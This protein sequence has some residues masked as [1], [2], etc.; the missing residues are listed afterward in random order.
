MVRI[1]QK[2]HDFIYLKNL[3]ARKRKRWT[4]QC[5]VV[6]V[7]QIL[8]QFKMNLKLA[9][10]PL[11]YCSVVLPTHYLWVFVS[12]ISAC[13]LCSGKYSW[14]RQVILASDTSRQVMQRYVTI[15][16][17]RRWCS[18]ASARQLILHVSSESTNQMM[19]RHVSTNICTRWCIWCS[20]M[21]LKQ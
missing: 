1:T 10:V 6:F 16:K 3:K 20:G 7:L 13:R 11:L 21:M 14:L 12:V 5:H 15:N 18:G 9:M 2:L 4:V 17:C 8:L 19:Q